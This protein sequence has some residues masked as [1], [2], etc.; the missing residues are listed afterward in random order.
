M[1]NFL[2]HWLT[3]DIDHCLQIISS[4]QASV[5]FIFSSLTL[6]L[7]S[8]CQW[9]ITM[10]MIGQCWTVL[11]SCW[12]NHHII[13]IIISEQSPLTLIIS[14]SVSSPAHWDTEQWIWSVKHSST[15]LS[16]CLRYQL[17]IGSFNKTVTALYLPSFSQYHGHMN[18]V[19][20]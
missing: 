15:V 10:L 16:Y 18:T 9:S 12:Y 19:P 13:N 5:R 14:L 1:H 2:H 4:V 7:V 6:I 11:L 20:E 8:W 17:D 3:V